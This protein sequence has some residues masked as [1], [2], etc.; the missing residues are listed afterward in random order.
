MRIPKRA[1]SLAEV[2][3][4]F[5]K[6]DN[7]SGL[8][9][10]AVSDLASQD[11]YFHWDDLAFRDPPAGL[12]R[13]TWWAQLKVQR[14]AAAHTLALRAKSAER[15]WFAS[16]PRA[17]RLLHRI[18]QQTA[19][20]IQ[21]PGRSDLRASGDRYLLSSIMEE[22][23]TSSQLEGAS[24][25]RRVAKQM[26]RAGRA[27]R[28]PDE[29]MIWNN[30]QAMRFIRDAKDRPLDRALLLEL[31]RIVTAGT[32]DEPTAEGR[33]R[34]TDDIQVIY[35]PDDTVVHDPPPAAELPERLDM[36]FE[37][38]NAD[39]EA[40]R[41]LHPV[42]RAIAIHF[43]LAYDHPFHDGNGRTARILFYWSMLRSGYSLAEYLS[44]SR[45]IKH[46]PVKYARAFLLTETDD[47][48]LTYF[49]L[50][51]LEVI[52]R[53]IDELHEWVRRSSDRNRHARR[54]IR[55][56]DGLN[57]RQVALLDH[58]LRHPDASYEIAVHQGYHNVS[59]P[60]ARADLLD[61]AD[62]QLLVQRKAGRK[63]VFFV[64]DDLGARVDGDA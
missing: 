40:G 50:H 11:R 58:A 44:V 16:T 30:Y 48:D 34:T 47:N 20:S 17:A 61:L 62:R 14:A 32:L 8:L 39:P 51:Q 18:D 21:V 28:T 45:I 36:L 43:Q 56:V 52:D 41:F 5:A 64:P 63:L 6:L 42:I 22:A 59:Y 26:L 1:P 23:I 29:R 46:A 53:A 13:A 35:R 54:L 19:G 27:P 7:A 60:T 38:A 10:H 37:F 25:T 12:T 9:L 3:E 55:K 4:D 31:H 57:A 49:V 15:F 33:L 2:V 24:T